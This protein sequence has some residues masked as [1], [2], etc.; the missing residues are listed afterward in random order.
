[1]LSL[2]KI[3]GMASGKDPAPLKP[4]NWRRFERCLNAKDSHAALAL[5]EPGRDYEQPNPR[6]GMKP[7]EY[8]LLMGNPAAAQKLLDCGASFTRDDRGRA[9][10]CE[11]VTRGYAGFVRALIDKGADPDDGGPND[12]TP[13]RTAVLNNQREIIDVLVEKGAALDGK[14]DS[15]GS[16]LTSATAADD[17]GALVR[18]LLQKGADPDV[19]NKHGETALMNAAKGLREKAVEAMIAGGADL[20]LRDGRGQTALF[21]ACNVARSDTP[22]IGALLDAGADPNAA[23]NTGIMPLMLAAARGGDANIDALV[24]KK[25]LLDAQDADGRT[26]LIWAARLG[27]VAVAR[28]LLDFGADPT[29]RDEEG[30]TACDRARARH[31]N[32]LKKNPALAQMLTEAEAGWAAKRNVRLSAEADA[33]TVLQADVR[34]GRALRLRGAMKPLA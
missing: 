4:F 22:V 5:I 10:L 15:E 28:K 14:P 20:G 32:D 24:A 2:K 33:S 21:I 12:F 34:V 26:A 27:T 6:F 9:L 19:P 18:L 8:C 25:A 23:D 16:P 13:L 1:M 29:L 7:I 17:D 11:A 3:F 30:K 31:A